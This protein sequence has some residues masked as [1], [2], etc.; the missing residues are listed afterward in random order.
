MSWF[1]YPVRFAEGIDRNV[2]LDKLLQRGIPA[3]PYFTP[4]HLQPF[5]RERFGYKEGD[6]PHAEAAGRSILA[7]P[8]YGSMKAEEV[9]VVCENLGEVLKELVG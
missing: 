2:V 5:Y 6:Y 1:V 3:R 7:L 8:F 9:Q 4:I